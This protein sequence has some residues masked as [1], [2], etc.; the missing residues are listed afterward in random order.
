[1]H[2]V[3]RGSKNSGPLQVSMGRSMRIF[4]EH[5]MSDWRLELRGLVKLSGVGSNWEFGD[6]PFWQHSVLHVRYTI[7]DDAHERLSHL[8]PRY[9]D[10]TKFEYL[11]IKSAIPPVNRSGFYLSIPDRDLALL[12]KLAWSSQ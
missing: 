9:T 12:F 6:R 7:N 10:H 8:D 11:L 3:V 2:S 5:S 1:M 4:Y